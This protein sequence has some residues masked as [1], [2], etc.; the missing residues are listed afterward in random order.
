MGGN[1]LGRADVEIGPAQECFQVEGQKKR[2]GKGPRAGPICMATQAT[3]AHAAHTRDV[4]ILSSSR[5]RGGQGNRDRRLG[6]TGGWW[7]TER[8]EQGGGTSGRPQGELGSSFFV[9]SSSAPRVP[10]PQTSPGWT[11]MAA[12]TGEPGRREEGV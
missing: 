2:G 1:G 10:S 5:T 8:S 11:T 6:L 12:V 3:L 7:A 9:R 4:P